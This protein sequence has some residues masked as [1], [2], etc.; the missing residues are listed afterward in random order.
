MARYGSS[1]HPSATRHGTPSRR[2]TAA[3]LSAAMRTELSSRRKCW[4]VRG[5]V[6]AGLLILTVW[7]HTR[8]EALGE[9]QAAYGRSNYVT[10][11][12]RACDHLD[13]SPW[14]REAARLAALCL[15]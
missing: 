4:I 15:S 13:R 2:I 5:L 9:A 1:S 3:R 8:W 10:G 12:R 14:S 11:L 6:L 7:N